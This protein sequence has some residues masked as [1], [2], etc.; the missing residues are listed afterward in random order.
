[1]IIQADATL[2]VY[3]ATAG[4]VR[5]PHENP[6]RPWPVAQL[7][8]PIQHVPSVR[9]RQWKLSVGIRPAGAGWPNS[10]NGS[11]LPRGRF[12]ETYSVGRVLTRL[13]V[14]IAEEPPGQTPAYENRGHADDEARRLSEIG[15]E[16]RL[17]EPARDEA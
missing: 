13:R 7:R 1:M 11:S 16:D 4:T 8:L 2:S 6:D 9:P 15:N 5:L 12:S 10:A 14:D 17:T 3:H